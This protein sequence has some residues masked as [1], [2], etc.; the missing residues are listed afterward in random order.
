MA[1]RQQ[2]VDLDQ[3]HGWPPPLPG[4]ING[5]AGR[6]RAI[7]KVARRTSVRGWAGIVSVTQTAM[8]P[9][10]AEKGAALGGLTRAGVGCRGLPNKLWWL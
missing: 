6:G 10:H 1:P 7:W 3:Q 4:A 8:R 9:S 5:S 2:Q